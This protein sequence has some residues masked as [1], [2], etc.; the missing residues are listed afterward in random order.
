M[1]PAP[2]QNP[3]SPGPRAARP[4]AAACPTRKLAP[5]LTT[6]APP[7]LP[8]RPSDSTQRPPSRARAPDI[9]PPVWRTDVESR[10]SGASYQSVR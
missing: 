4:A 3:A 10:A 8:P 6:R 2:P 1:I 9:A 5:R 7:I